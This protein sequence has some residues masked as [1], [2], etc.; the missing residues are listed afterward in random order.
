MLDA[1]L[2]RRPETMVDRAGRLASVLVL[3]LVAVAP[4]CAPLYR[5]PDPDTGIGYLAGELRAT[6]DADPARVAVATRR[7]FQE[8]Q[9][10]ERF[11]D[12]SRLDAE[13]TGRTGRGKRVW[14]VVRDA[15]PGSSLVRIRVG[16]L[17]DG[18]MSRSLLEAIQA[19]LR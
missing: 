9:I 19:S 13:F 6:V 18:V 5:K 1:S 2:P 17:G 11:A 4:G 15:G 16:P 7:A 12:V 14:V 8:L 10:R 3:G